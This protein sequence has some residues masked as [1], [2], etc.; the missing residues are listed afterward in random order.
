MGGCPP[1]PKLVGVIQFIK[2]QKHKICIQNLDE[3][4]PFR[5]NKSYVIAS[6]FKILH[7]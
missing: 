6:G 1:P 4:I 2:F 7:N 3:E 5:S